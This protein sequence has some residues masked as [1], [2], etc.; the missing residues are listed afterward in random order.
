MGDAAVPESGVTASTR[1]LLSRVVTVEDG[2]WKATLLAFVFFF[3]LLASY[4]IL[5]SIRDALGVQA[6]VGAL[7]WLFSGTLVSTI[8]LQPVAGWL[9]AKYPVRTF[10]RYSYRAFF[11]CLLFFA[12]SISWLPHSEKWLA[13][14]FFVWTSVFNLFVV[15]VFWGF[16]S[17]N[18]TSEQSKRLYG[19]ISVGGTVG[20]MAGS[21]ITALLAKKTGIVP[22]VL[23]SALMLE[24][25]VQCVRVFPSSFRTDTRVREA[26]LKPIGGDAWSAFRHV[27]RSPYLLMICL[28]MLLF[29]IGSTLLYFQQA[30]IVKAEF[31]DRN[32]QTAF[33]ARIDFTVQSLTVLAQLFLTGRIIK[34]LGVGVT[35][36]ILPVM[37]IIGFSAM[38]MWPVLA[39]FVAFNV[40]RR[41]GNYGFSSPGREVLFTVVSAEDK[42]KA[43]NLIDTGVYRSGDQIGAWTSAFITKAG[44]GIAAISWIAAPMSVAWL[45]VA[46]W[47]GRRHG[48][49][50]AAEQEEIPTSAVLAV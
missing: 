32:S 5:R 1:R 31:H 23:L 41:A 19:F 17:D 25:T 27:V 14:V 38:G 37:S 7:P 6:G 18:F 29:T 9:V 36:S 8:V 42:Y 13:P 46:I 26:A 44:L 47:L 21:L 45:L 40:L 39:V 50:Q 33:L 2:E 20:A 48:K 49:M 43:K 28:F 35:L 34:W 3:F 11:A 16:T 22:L 30:V 4:F 24:V 10:I 12:A 15:S